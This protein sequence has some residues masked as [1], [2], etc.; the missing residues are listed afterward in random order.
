VGGHTALTASAQCP[1][2]PYHHRPRRVCIAK[3]SSGEGICFT[4]RGFL[5][6]FF[7]L[8]C[9]LRKLG[10]GVYKIWPQCV[11]LSRRR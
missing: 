2:S 6:F 8:K 5:Y 4:V 10:T 3:R 1:G 11:K 7:F 9:F